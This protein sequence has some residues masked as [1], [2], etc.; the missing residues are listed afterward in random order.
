[1][2]HNNLTYLPRVRDPQRADTI[3][4]HHLN[5]K[6]SHCHMWERA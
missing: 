4:R 3:H 5:S 1:M 2:G 6:G